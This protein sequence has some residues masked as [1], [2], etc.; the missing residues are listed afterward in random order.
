MPS[1]SAPGAADE[2]SDHHIVAYYEERYPGR[3]PQP[4]DLTNEPDPKFPMYYIV[5]AGR[6]VGI[7]TDWNLV[8][9]LVMG[10][11]KARFYK[12]KEYVQAWAAYRYSWASKRVRVLQTHQDSAP[13]HTQ[14]ADSGLDFSLGNAPL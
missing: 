5:T 7:F 12:R 4:K 8:S 6:S 3:V 10:V 2:S 11:S 14:L 13:L 9:D 1:Q